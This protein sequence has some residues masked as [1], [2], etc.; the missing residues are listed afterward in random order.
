MPR[1]SRV[2]SRSSDGYR[3]NPGAGPRLRSDVIDV[4]VFREATG[5]RRGTSVRRRKAA[6][7]VAVEFLQMR[8][9]KPPLAGTWHPVMGHIEPGETAVEAALREMEEEVGLVAGRE[10][11]AGVWALEQV[12]PFY[13]H[14]IDCI[15]LS[16]RFAARV[17]REWVPRLNEEHS[18]YRWVAA[19]KA[20][21]VFMWPGQAACVREIVEHLRATRTPAAEHQRIV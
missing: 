14:A 8:R 9:A 2:L 7:P 13:L 10:P 12:H 19:A 3:R 21:E 17:T 18:A 5:G 4:Y 1:S 11:C 15:V 16:P 6:A 20:S